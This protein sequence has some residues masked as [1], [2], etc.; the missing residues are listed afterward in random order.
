MED[1]ASIE[2]GAPIG[3]GLDEDALRAPSAASEAPADLLAELRELRECFDAKIRYDQAKERQ[4]EALHEEL[5][6]H[7]Q[8][9]Y[10]QIMRP[11]LIDLIDIYD[12]MSG[13]LAG[14]DGAVPDGLGFLAEMV[15]ERALA[16]RGDQVHL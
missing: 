2:D 8:G 4:I 16:I 3:A 12:E 1:G 15:E 11:V 6:A 10:Q 13:L 7:R 14:P 9:L 5:Q